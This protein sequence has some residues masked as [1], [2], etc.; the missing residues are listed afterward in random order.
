VSVLDQGSQRRG[1]YRVNLDRVG[2]SGRRVSRGVHVIRLTV[3]SE[4]LS[5]KLALVR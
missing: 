5:R 2:E 4:V 3:G 1:E